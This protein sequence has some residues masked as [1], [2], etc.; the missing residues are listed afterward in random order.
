MGAGARRV[1]RECKQHLTKLLVAFPYFL[2]LWSG[3]FYNSPIEQQQQQQ[4]QRRQPLL[5]SLLVYSLLTDSFRR[6]IGQKAAKACLCAWASGQSREE[7]GHRQKRRSLIARHKRKNTC[8]KTHTHT[9][10]WIAE[11]V[12]PEGKKNETA[13]SCTIV[14]QL[15]RRNATL[16]LSLA[17]ESSA[18]NID[19]SE[20]RN[21]ATSGHHLTR[22]RASAL[23]PYLAGLVEQAETWNNPICSF[24]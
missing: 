8:T 7:S 23:R 14:D 12:C 18:K 11:Q 16:A 4:Q 21:A 1:D 2:P 6:L 24:I 13:G 3:S 19:N 9:H 5:A 17:P 15:D 22:T 20:L 10:T